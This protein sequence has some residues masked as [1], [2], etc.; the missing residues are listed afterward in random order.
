MPAFSGIFGMPFNP[1]PQTAAQANYL[2]DF[3]PAFDAMLSLYMPQFQ[4]SN[5]FN[6]LGGRGRS[7]LSQQWDATPA[8]QAASGVSP[9]DMT[10]SVDFLK[11]INPASFYQ[12]YAP[13]E[14]GVQGQ[15]AYTPFTRFR[16]R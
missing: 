4:G 5:F 2:T 9:L 11:G 15:Q 10:S 8:G 1:Q 6:W 7:A 14:R 13:N 16:T 12:T 3:D